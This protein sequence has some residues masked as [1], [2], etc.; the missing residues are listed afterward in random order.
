M[1]LKRLLFLIAF[2]FFIGWLLRDDAKAE[3]NEK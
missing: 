3:C 2:G 1:T